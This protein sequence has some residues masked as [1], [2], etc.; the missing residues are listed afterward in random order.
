[1]SQ[2]AFGIVCLPPDSYGPWTLSLTGSFSSL[3]PLSLTLIS[4]SIRALLIGV[5]N[6]LFSV[7]AASVELP[8]PQAARTAAN[9]ARQSSNI[10]RLDRAMARQ[11]NASHLK[12]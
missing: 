12:S 2:S 1:M 4:R 7:A 10:G 6:A 11:G 9:A 5:E 3:T 8:L